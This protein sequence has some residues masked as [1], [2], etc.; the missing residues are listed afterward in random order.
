MRRLSWTTA[1]LDSGKSEEAQ[2]HHWSGIDERQLSGLCL[3]WS[4]GR[5]WGAWLTGS[6]HQEQPDGFGPYADCP[7]SVVEAW[8]AAIRLSAHKPPGDFQLELPVS[9]APPIPD[10]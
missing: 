3:D 10:V 9:K 5:D 1:M 2:G 8:D 6:F 7:V 4:T